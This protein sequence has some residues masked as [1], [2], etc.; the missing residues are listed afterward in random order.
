MH[1]MS[2]IMTHTLLHF[3]I[4]PGVLSISL[5]R[6]VFKLLHRYNTRANSKK[7]MENLEQENRELR[8][9]VTSLRAGMANMTAMVE[10]LVAAQNKPL[11]HPPSPHII[12][13]KQTTFIFEIQDAHVSSVPVVSTV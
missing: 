1:C 5:L 10:Q 7:K 2:C 3:H 13:P 9:E 11:P 6:S 8:E 4:L 12:Q